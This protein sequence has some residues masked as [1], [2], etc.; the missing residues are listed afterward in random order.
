MVFLGVHF[1]RS[2]KT[3]AHGLGPTTL[4]ISARTSSASIVLLQFSA[5]LPVALTSGQSRP[6]RLSKTT[7]I[8]IDDPDHGIGSSKRQ[9]IGTW[10]QERPHDWFRGIWP[11]HGEELLHLLVLLELLRGISISVS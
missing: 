9:C 5:E 2:L 1:T 8:V 11:Q 6:R 4:S 3:G 10:A 7:H